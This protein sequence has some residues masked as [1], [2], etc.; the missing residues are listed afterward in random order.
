MKMPC[1]V[2]VWQVLPM[3]RRELAGELVSSHGMTQSEVARRFG[4]TDAAV[5]QYLTRKRGGDYSDSPLYPR[6]IDAVRDAASRIARGADA[7]AESCRLCGVVGGI[8]L[9]DEIYS[10]TTGSSLPSC[11]AAA[12]ARR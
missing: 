3:V 4:V 1:E 10:R 5:S 6:F 8:G 2:V 7:G 11:D 9:L 12:V